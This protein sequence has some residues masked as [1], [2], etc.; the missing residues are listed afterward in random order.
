[1]EMATNR[2]NIEMKRNNKG[3]TLIELLVTLAILS[4]VVM[5]GAPSFQGAMRSS[6]LTASINEFFT[7]I[8]LVRSEAVKRNRHVVMRKKDDVNWEG[9][10]QIFV[11]VDRSTA[12]K[13][14]VFNDNGDT[15]LCEP[16]EDC[17]LKEQEAL[18][19]HFTLHPSSTNF[20][21]FIRYTPIG[22]VGNSVAG[23]SF[24]LCDT[25]TSLTPAIGTARV[26]I[27]NAIGRPRMAVN[28]TTIPQVTANTNITTC[29][30][31]P[32]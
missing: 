3:F 5:I 14:N 22:V 28:N 15:N 30:P 4:I 19:P 23:V 12:A 11:D 2:G 26:L 29:T 18:P 1:M 10:W 8:N 27:L 21:N 31:L 17:L 9:G 25:T 24:Y 7:A 20:I 6:R 16:T 32:K 13:E